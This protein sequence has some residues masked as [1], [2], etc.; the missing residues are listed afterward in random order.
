MKVLGCSLLL[1][2]ACRLSAQTGTPPQA[3]VPG[4]QSR[5]SAVRGTISKEELLIPPRAV[6]ELQRSQAA[7]ES[8]D[9]RSSTRH[10]E[11]ALQIY[12]E[13]LDAH[14]NLGAQYIELNEY[15]KAAVE[16]QKAIQM[17]PQAA[18]PFNNLSV[19]LFHLKRYEEAEAAARRGLALNP[20]HS[21][22]R[23][24][25]GCILAREN[26]SPLEA[27]ELLRESKSEF[28][29]SRLV[30]AEILL[31]RGAVEEGQRELQEYLAMPGNEKKA[32]VERWLAQLARTP[33]SGTSALRVDK[34]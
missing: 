20:Q 2:L 30:L 32:E 26:R 25:L 19:A 34:P 29:D 4:D 7:F 5:Q 12:P 24:V 14:N 31:R 10:L 23:Y 21:A 27:M 3:L 15:E 22:T 16:L 17:N 1:I 8:G 11:K 6:R 28:P 33:A 18:Q 9:L 13:Y